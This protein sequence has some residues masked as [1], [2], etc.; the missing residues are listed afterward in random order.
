MGPLVYHKFSNMT[1]L[2]QLQVG[3]GGRPDRNLGSNAPRICG[4][5]MPVFTRVQNEAGPLRRP[6][7]RLLHLRTITSLNFRQ[8]LEDWNALFRGEEV[9]C[10]TRGTP[11]L[12]RDVID[13]FT[14]DLVATAP[15]RGNM[16]VRHAHVRSSR[17][18]IRGAYASSESSFRCRH[19]NGQDDQ[20][21]TTADAA[22]SSLCP[23]LGG[24]HCVYT[25]GRRLCISS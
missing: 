1:S 19:Q 5:S 18:Q 6:R 17:A 25:R 16:G 2:L 23:A 3:G 24:L 15:A 11:R 12:D 10:K 22:R 8:R 4:S 7:K 13:P 9:G 21:Q 14:A 20:T